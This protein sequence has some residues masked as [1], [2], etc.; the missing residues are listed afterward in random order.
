[1]RGFIET[2]ADTDYT[3]V[4]EFLEADR[5]TIEVPTGEHLKRELKSFEAVLQFFFNG[6]GYC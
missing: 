5:Y 6:T 4:R 2:D 3:K 1:M